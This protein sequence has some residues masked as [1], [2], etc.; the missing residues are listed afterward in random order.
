[1]TLRVFVSRANQEAEF[2]QWLVKDLRLTGTDVW[3]D[4]THIGAGNVLQIINLAINA[5]DVLVLVLTSYAL[6]S[7]RVPDEMD[8]AQVA[9]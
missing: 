8:S 5:R 1:M 4:A 2:A 9:I 6:S 7:Q 3:L